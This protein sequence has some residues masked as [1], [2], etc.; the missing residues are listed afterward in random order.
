MAARV[1][2]LPDPVDAEA[3]AVGQGERQVARPLVPR[4]G[5][6]V[7]VAVDQVAGDAGRVVRT[8]QGQ[9]GDGDLGTRSP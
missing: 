2:D 4:R 3:A 5:Q 8:Q 9:F 6:D 1:A 7:L